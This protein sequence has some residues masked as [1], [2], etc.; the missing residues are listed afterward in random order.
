VDKSGFRASGWC[1]LRV[2]VLPRDVSR[3]G[4]HTYCWGYGPNFVG[5]LPG[6]SPGWLPGPLGEAPASVLRLLP[7][8][9]VVS[10]L[11]GHTYCWG[12]GPNFVGVLPGMSPGL[13]LGPL[14]RRSC[15]GSSDPVL[16]LGCVAS[17]GTHL[18]LGLRAEL[19]WGSARYV[20]GVVAWSLGVRLLLRF[21]GS[22][23]SARL[24][25]VLGYTV[26]L[27][28]CPPCPRCWCFAISRLGAFWGPG[29]GRETGV[30]STTGRCRS[31]SCG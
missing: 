5:D 2:G 11:G 30:E 22:C 24:C 8:G 12:Y 7:F 29:R 13:L 19:R 31:A 17:W 1:W 6:M 25:C 10:R 21:F 28:F 18:L 16:R 15:F 4:G 23:P 14:G 20:P 9:A 27:G 3:L 26:L